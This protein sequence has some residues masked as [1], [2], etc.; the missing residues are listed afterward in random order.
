M[1]NLRQMSPRIC[2]ADSGFSSGSISKETLLGGKKMLLS[3]HQMRGCRPLYSES[4]QKHGLQ[5]F[6]GVCSL[7]LIASLFSGAV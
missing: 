6:L 4:Q 1:K 3:V 2:Q 7:G 5:S